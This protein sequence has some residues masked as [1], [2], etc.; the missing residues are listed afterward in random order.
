MRA[1]LF[2]NVPDPGYSRGDR[3]GFE[4]QWLERVVET[5]CA[6]LRVARC[7]ADGTPWC[8]LDDSPLLRWLPF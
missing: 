7:L 6:E 5:E 2:V 1:H 4:Q 3:A 8:E